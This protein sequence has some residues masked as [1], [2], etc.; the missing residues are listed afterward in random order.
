MAADA[1]ELA[2]FAEAAEKAL[3]PRL[4]AELAAAQRRIEEHLRV[5]QVRAPS[6]RWCL[7]DG[8]QAAGVHAFF[9]SQ[10]CF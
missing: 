5:L 1:R 10:W 9:K 4:E 2:G 6:G 8:R 3:A 7:G